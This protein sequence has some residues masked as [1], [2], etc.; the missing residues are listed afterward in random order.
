MRANACFASCC[1]YLAQRGGLRKKFILIP[2]YV[3]KAALRLSKI[4]S[5]EMWK[6]AWIAPCFVWKYRRAAFPV[7]GHRAGLL[8]GGLPPAGTH[9]GFG[10]VF[11]VT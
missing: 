4:A 9:A 6:K 2:Y 8:S 3:N 7:R 10:E 1:V 11:T 5:E